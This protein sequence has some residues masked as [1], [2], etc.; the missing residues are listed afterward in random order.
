MKYEDYCYFPKIRT[1]QAELLG[2]EKLEEDTKKSILPL[3]SITTLGQRKTVASVVE[4]LEDIVLTQDKPVMI[5]FERNAHVQCTDFRE[6]IDPSNNYENWTNFFRD[7]IKEKGLNIIPCLIP[8]ELIDNRRDYAQHIRAMERMFAHFFIKID[9]FKKRDV[10]AAVLVASVC[11]NLKDKLFIID[12]GQIDQSRIKVI[13]QA[14][15]FVINELREIDP[16]INITVQGSSFP[17]SFVDYGRTAGSISMLEWEL[18]S[19]L[20]GREVCF[21]GDYASIHGEFYQ[22][23]YATFVARVDYPAEKMWIFERRPSPSKDE[24]NREA[25]YIQACNAIKENDFWDSDLEC[26]GK[27][28]IETVSSGEVDGFKSPAKWISVRVNLHIERMKGFIEQGL[29]DEGSSFEAE[30]D[31]LDDENW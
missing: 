29:L 26:W 11:S 12:V 25:L 16:S 22:G 15:I 3:I 21:Y 6:Y 27:Q 5:E 14:V 17:R 2:F 7:L 10:T 1:R 4:K 30:E 28:V 24:V 8:A 19:H 31:I 18:F 20:G 9:P 13:E 23:S